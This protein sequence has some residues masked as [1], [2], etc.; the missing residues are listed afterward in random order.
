MQAII[1]AIQKAYQPYEISKF[2]IKNQRQGTSNINCRI[3]ELI[4][5]T[6]PLPS[7][8]AKYPHRIVIVA[9]TKE[10]EIILSA[11]IPII[12]ISELA[13]NRLSS[14]LGKIQNNIVPNK[15]ITAPVG[16]KV[17]HVLL[18]RVKFLLP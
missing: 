4:I 9:N 13:E 15:A 12:S 5:L 6:I 10:I 16:S 3:A 8:E 17:F 11:G 7:P 2:F 1:S 18:T 14:C